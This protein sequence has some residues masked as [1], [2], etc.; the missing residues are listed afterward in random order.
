[1]FT[2]RG[3]NQDRHSVVSGVNY[4][5][6]D[7]DLNSN[8]LT[9]INNMCNSFAWHMGEVAAQIGGFDVAHSHDWLATKA[10]VQ[11]RNNHNYPCVFTIHSTEF[12]RCGNQNCD[13]Q[14]RL[15]R[16][17]EWEGAYCADRVIAVSGVLRSEFLHHYSL[18]EDKVTTLYNGVLADRFAG[19]I[20]V[21]AAKTKLGLGPC[22]PT[23]L[24]CGRLAWQKAPD[25][26]IEAVPTVLSQHPTSK[27]LIV[28]DGEMRSGLEARVQ[29]LG[30]GHAV[31]FLGCRRGQ[32][33]ADLFNVPDVVCVPSRNEPFGIV[34]LEA[35]SAGKPVVV[36]QNGGP[37]EFVRQGV[38]GIKIHDRVESIAWGLLEGFRDFDRLREMGQ[39]G[40][41]RARSEF[42]WDSIARQTEQVYHQAIQSNRRRLGLPDLAA[43]VPDLANAVMPMPVKVK[44]T[45][46]R[47]STRVR[48]AA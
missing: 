11:A 32:E 44:R 8:F 24:F 4:H 18:P 42:N 16:D 1:M 23:V 27:F 41:E 2:R 6:C 15:I 37:A 9:E 17:M 20:D 12:G 39:A 34:I 43:E 7:F 31:R 14:S 22:D 19:P 10:L 33:L 35:W 40:R 46:R 48:K 30:I 5:R 38:D 13:G 47:T 28:G 25:L 26:F 21:G 45:A 29:T 3:P 36:T